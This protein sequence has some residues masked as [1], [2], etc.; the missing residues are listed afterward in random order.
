MGSD[1]Q[2]GII[3]ATR[4]GVAAEGFGMQEVAAVNIRSILICECKVV[5]VRILLNLVDIGAVDVGL[6]CVDPLS[7]GSGISHSTAD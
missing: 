1:R 2:I 7:S 5:C 6:V 3:L 4:K